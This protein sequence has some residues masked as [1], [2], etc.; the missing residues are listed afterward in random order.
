MHPQKYENKQ[1]KEQEGETTMET[2]DGGGGG[3]NFT[4]WQKIAI[5]MNSQ[6][7]FLVSRLQSF[8]V[9][10]DKALSVAAT[11]LS[12]EVTWSRVS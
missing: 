4:Q 2:W 9:M 8:G 10:T 1:N 11:H 7:F 3:G 5:E 12:S 6:F